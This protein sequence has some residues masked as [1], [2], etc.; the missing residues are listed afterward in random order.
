MNNSAYRPDES[1]PEACIDSE[2]LYRVELTQQFLE[3]R[4]WLEQEGMENR[5]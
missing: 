4:S 2:E 5:G 1:T 3:M